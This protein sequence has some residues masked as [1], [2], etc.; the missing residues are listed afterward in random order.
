MCLFI[1]FSILLHRLKPLSHIIINQTSIAIINNLLL[2]III[3]CFLGP[4]LQHMKIPR[5]GVELEIQLPAYAIAI[6]MWNPSCFCN[7][8]HS[9]KKCWILNL[10]SEARD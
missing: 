5:L 4:H 6:A 8:H 10:L 2:I 3:I 9:S 1:S 7:I